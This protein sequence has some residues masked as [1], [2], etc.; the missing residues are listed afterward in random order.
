MD[1]ALSDAELNEFQVFLNLFY[2]SISYY[3][4]CF[5]I[6]NIFRGLHL[7]F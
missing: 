6:F 4:G 2:D 1:G 7:I 3:F 5:K